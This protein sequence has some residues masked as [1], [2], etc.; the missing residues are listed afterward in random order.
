MAKVGGSERQF[1]DALNVAKVRSDNLDWVY[2]QKWA[3]EL[4]IREL[5]EKL[6]DELGKWK[7]Q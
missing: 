7:K 1:T 4:E 3:G 5:L 2:L 6:R